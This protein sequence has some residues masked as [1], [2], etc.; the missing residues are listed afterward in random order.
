M[1]AMRPANRI[2]AAGGAA[3]VGAA[4][5]LAACTPSEERARQ[6]AIAEITECE[7]LGYRKG[8][9]GMADCRL[10]LREIQAQE[11]VARSNRALQ[12]ELMFP[13]HLGWDPWCRCRH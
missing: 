11:A 1:A 12:M 7:S 10:R 9:E 6:Q 2:V 3:L 5:V 13:S 8:T 4:F